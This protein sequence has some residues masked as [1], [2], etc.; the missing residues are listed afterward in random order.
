MSN[1]ISTGISG[2]LAFQRAIDTISHNIA[3]VATEGYS[4]QRTEFVT[5]PAN[6]YGNGWV[7]NGVDVSTTRRVY[8][9]LLAAQVRDSSSTFSSLNTFATYMDRLNNLFASTETGLTATLQ[10]FVNALQDVANTPSSVPARQV[11]L[12]EARGLAERLRSYDAQLASYD[13]QIESQLESEAREISMLADG[14]AQLNVK[15]SASYAVFAQP[16]NDLLDQRDRLIDQLS[17]HI[18]VSTVPQADGTVNVFIGTGQSL[19]VGGKAS[20]VV[21]L[22]DPYDAGRHRMGLRLDN[23]NPADITSTLTGGSLGGALEFREQVLDPARNALGRISVALA[24]VMNEQHAAGMDLSGA[25]G[26]EFFAVGGVDVLNHFANTGDATFEITRTDISAITE[27]DY[28]LELTATG[29]LLRREDTG[30]AVP[31]TGTGTPGDPL[32]GEGLSIVVNNTANVGDR[33]LIRPTRAA[34]A[35]FDVLIS[36]PGKVAAAA[37]IRTS[38]PSTNTGTGTISA[39]KVVDA[40]H[41]Q[42]RDTVT[43]EFLDAS[44]YTIDGAGPFNYTSGEPI[45]WNG[46]EV[47]I[48]GAPAAGDTFTVQENTGGAGDNRN[49]LAMIQALSSKVLDGDTAS[50]NET[51]TRLVGNI[52]VTTRQVQASRD[53][54]EVIRQESV[55]ARNAVS[56]VN[57]DEEA[58]NLLRFQQAYQAAA[59]LINVANSLFESLLAATSRR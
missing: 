11:L 23:G 34:T 20:E 59:Q 52:G 5:R 32:I 48:S 26:G 49:A 10:K 12:S 37:P 36:D 53:A 51:A 24:S 40:S 3:N 54:Q 35:A 1:F 27:G 15:I 2:L 18:D 6:P 56:G 50:I 47:Q 28:Y 16:P 13:R 39:G 14:I 4:R 9:D 57:L 38:T 29:W 31:L 42:L 58:A 45:T 7:G 21:T 46:W 33:F 17:T 55:D 22:R 19:V 41:P 43:I 44:T 30:S 8:D 25:P